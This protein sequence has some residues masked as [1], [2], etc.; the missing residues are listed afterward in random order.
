M[1]SFSV[2]VQLLI[3]IQRYVYITSNISVRSLPCLSFKAQLWENVHDMINSTERSD[4]LV[5]NLL[6]LSCQIF[7]YL[8]CLQHQDRWN[9]WHI[10]VFW[11]LCFSDTWSSHKGLCCGIKVFIEFYF[12]ISRVFLIFY[13]LGISMIWA[14]FH[15][16]REQFYH[17]L[18]INI[19]SL[20]Y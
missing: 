7:A 14:I 2:D 10:Q 17:K 18:R 6:P 11:E 5:F 19:T 20:P 16:R 13:L 1:M 4:I 12:I 15:V 8:L 9:F 3:R